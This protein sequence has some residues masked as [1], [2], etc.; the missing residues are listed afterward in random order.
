MSFWDKYFPWRKKKEEIIIPLKPGQVPYENKSNTMW[1][2]LKPINLAKIETVQF[3]D[4]LYIKEIHQKKQLV[5]HHTVSGDGVN[6]DIA[7]WEN[8][9]RRIATCII[10]DRA[11]TPWQL[12][13]SKYWAYHLGAGNENLDKHSIGIEIDNWGGLV[14]GDGTVKQFGLKPDGT[15]RMVY[16]EPNKHYNVYGKITYAVTEYYPNEF[17]GYNYYEKYTDAQIQTVGELL[18]YWRMIYGISLVYNEDM[19]DKS[20]RA[21]RGDN[22]LWTHVSYRGSGKSDCHPQPEL[23]SMLK[24]LDGIK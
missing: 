4:N 7:T 6:G 5:L 10:V 11:G 15:A 3:S 16:T 8:D 18:L 1:S 24:T 22:G 9:P 13:S 17:M 2:N 20:E 12:F 19:W 21:L 23:I 14:L